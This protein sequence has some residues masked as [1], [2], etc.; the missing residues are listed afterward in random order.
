MQAFSVVPLADMDG[1]HHI[2]SL[3]STVVSHDD[4][5][6]TLRQQLRQSPHMPPGLSK[7]LTPVDEKTEKVHRFSEDEE[8]DAYSRVG[9]MGFSSVLSNPG[10][11][12]M[13]G[14]LESGIGSMHNFDMESVFSAGDPPRRILVSSSSAE[15]V[16]EDQPIVT[17]SQEDYRRSSDVFKDAVPGI[18]GQNKE[19]NSS[20]ESIGHYYDPMSKHTKASLEQEGSPT[21]LH[22]FSSSDEATP[23]RMS[24]EQMQRSPGREEQRGSEDEIA[25]M[26]SWDPM[27]PSFPEHLHHTTQQLTEY[28][29]QNID[30]AVAPGMSN[31]QLASAE[32]PGDLS[33]TSLLHLKQHH[34]Y[35]SPTVSGS[36]CEI[37]T[38][39]EDHSE[40]E[41][42]LP[43]ESGSLTSRSFKT[44]YSSPVRHRR[45]DKYATS[46]EHFSPTCSPVGIEQETEEVVTTFDY[47]S[48]ESE[49]STLMQQP[50]FSPS[51]VSYKGG[52]TVQGSMDTNPHTSRNST[53]PFHTTSVSPWHDKRRKI[54]INPLRVLK[55]AQTSPVLPIPPDAD[56]T[57]MISPE[58]ITAEKSGDKLKRS[59]SCGLFDGTK[60]NPA[61]PEPLHTIAEATDVKFGQMDL[62]LSTITK[63][64]Y[65]KSL[66]Y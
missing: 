41:L 2:Q 20:Q 49:H 50:N 39:A 60:Y 53:S 38:K 35:N 46:D 43:N 61:S 52:S 22:L 48:D 31:T 5:I 37:E 66:K 59:R 4:A 10:S 65:E 57:R 25:S 47:E 27:S 24:A 3:P 13:L 33:L 45:Q 21:S 15:N 29:T 54:R 12:G 36:R 64:E 11:I 23:D 26:R 55:V 56:R 44:L 51:I 32:K 8:D 42:N 1:H 19:T 34:L 63:Q 18:L 6:N 30:S 17:K 40:L 9:R 62:D 14:D 16:M 28:S 7:T 58:D